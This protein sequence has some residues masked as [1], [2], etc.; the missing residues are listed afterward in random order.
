MADRGIPLPITPG[1]EIAGTVERLG[2]EAKLE[3]SAVKEGDRVVVYPWIG[4]GACRNCRLGRENICESKPKTL[5]IFRDGGYAEFVLVPDVRYLILSG[6]L[7]PRMAL[8]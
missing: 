5:G 6:T 1:H 7:V 4:C 8:L 2:A 3:Q